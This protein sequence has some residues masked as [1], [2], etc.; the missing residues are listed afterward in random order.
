MTISIMAVAAAVAG[1]GR[2]HV[3]VRSIFVICEEAVEFERKETLHQR[4]AIEIGELF[5]HRLHIRLDQ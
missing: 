1:V 2:P 4:L 5:R 3:D